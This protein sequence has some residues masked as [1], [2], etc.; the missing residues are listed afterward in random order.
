MKT[1]DQA[2]HLSLPDRY[3]SIWRDPGKDWMA[4][5]MYCNLLFAGRTG[6]ELP[7]LL[8]HSPVGRRL[9][10]L[11]VLKALEGFWQRERVARDPRLTIEAGM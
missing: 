8:L 9:R 2:K 11:N 10:I 3:C 4:V 5:S 7:S 1:G 6:E